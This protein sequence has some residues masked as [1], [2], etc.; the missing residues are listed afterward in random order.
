MAQQHVT[1]QTSMGFS[2]GTF[3]ADMA[4][5]SGTAVSEQAA[6]EVRLL[7]GSCACLACSCRSVSR[8]KAARF[9][10]ASVLDFPPAIE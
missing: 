2:P 5:A 3:A 1:S 7:D 8:K 9:G 10:S 4:S 6:G